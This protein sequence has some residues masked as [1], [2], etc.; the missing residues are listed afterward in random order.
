ML[1][2]D[3]WYLKFNIFKTK[4]LLPPPN[5]QTGSAVCLFEVISTPSF[6]LLKPNTWE[7]AGTFFHTVNFIHCKFP[8][9]FMGLFL[10]I[11]STPR[12]DIDSLHHLS[13]TW[14]AKPHKWCLCFHIEPCA[15]LNIEAKQNDPVKMYT[16]PQEPF[17]SKPPMTS[18]I[19][20][21]KCPSFTLICR[22]PTQQ[23]PGLFL[24]T[25]L[26]VACF[27]SQVP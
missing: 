17:G 8:T 5:K 20:P 12:C 13:L 24:I 22:N 1:T 10:T 18:S 11:F 3:T 14:D 2:C 26:V 23:L 21:I 27:P 25:F 4:L 15:T 19:P 16:R 6:Q 7:S 9:F